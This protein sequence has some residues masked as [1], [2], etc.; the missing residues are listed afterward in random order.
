MPLYIFVEFEILQVKTNTVL[1][2]SEK[3]IDWTSTKSSTFI[4]NYMPIQLV[5]LPQIYAHAY[6]CM[7]TTTMIDFNDKY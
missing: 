4:Y 5:C 3:M 1:M 2:I 7:L 6:S